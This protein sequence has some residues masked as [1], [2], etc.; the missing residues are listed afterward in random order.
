MVIVPLVLF[1]VFTSRQSLVSSVM[2]FFESFSTCFSLHVWVLGCLN[3]F[4]ITWFLQYGCRALDLESQGSIPARMPVRKVLYI[5]CVH[6]H[7]HNYNVCTDDNEVTIHVHVTLGGGD[8]L[9]GRAQT[10]S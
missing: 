10:I 9:L 5:V 3:S 8:K 1:I 7:V 4:N 2:I 6:L